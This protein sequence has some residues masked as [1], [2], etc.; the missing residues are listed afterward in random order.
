MSFHIRLRTKN[1]RVAQLVADGTLPD[2]QLEIHGNE[3]YWT[4]SIGVAQRGEDGQF[5]TSASHTALKAEHQT[6]RPLLD[7]DDE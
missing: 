7:A 6:E 5:K 3:D 2:G 1:G 4:H